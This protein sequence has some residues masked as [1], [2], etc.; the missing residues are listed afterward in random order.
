M[1]WIKFCI[2]NRI[3]Y[4]I[5]RLQKEDSI[6]LNNI[7]PD[8][9]IIILSGIVYI[10]KVFANREVSPIA[11]LNENNIFIKNQKE[12]KIHYTMVALQTT[13]IININHNIHKYQKGNILTC[14]NILNN[15]K[16][17]Y[18][19][20]EVINKIV[21]QKQVK[22]RILQLIF[23]LSLQYGIIK[24]QTIFIPFNLSYH[25]IAILTGTSKNTVVKVM[26]KMYA[27]G[28]KR[29]IIHNTILIK[30]ILNLKLQ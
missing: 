16:Q 3:P 2:T 17:T 5:Y 23:I 12:N 10:T 20:Y 22:H 27:I 29:D 30:N 11:I 13:Y 24:G 15:Y 26:K 19:K 25:N 7:K 21:C 4:Y 6:I 9:F 18:E 8:G 28:I 1:K 14:I